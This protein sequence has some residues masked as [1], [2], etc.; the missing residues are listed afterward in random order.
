MPENQNSKRI[1]DLEE[2]TYQFAKNVR[3]YIKN[4]RKPHRILK[5]ENKL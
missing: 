4:Y 1:Y 2:R 3:L 5:M